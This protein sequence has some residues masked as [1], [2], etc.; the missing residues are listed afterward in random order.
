MRIFSVAY[1]VFMFQP[2]L[3]FPGFCLIYQEFLFFLLMFYLILL[4][5]RDLFIFLLS[6][7]VCL[8]AGAGKIIRMVRKI[9]AVN[10]FRF[11]IGMGLLLVSL[12]IYYTLR[13]HRV[14]EMLKS[15]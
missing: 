13:Q 9:V 15:G 7:C 12:Q 14:N 4:K 5:D 2:L 3:L 10:N 8:V 1:K 6:S 11:M